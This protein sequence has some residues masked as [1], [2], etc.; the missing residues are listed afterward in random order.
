MEEFDGF[1][2]ASGGREDGAIVG[3]H[4][5]E[6]VL[7]VLG[8]IDAWLGRD[9]KFGTEEGTAGAVSPER[10]EQQTFA[11]EESSRNKRFLICEL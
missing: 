9:A 2:G 8:V 4:D 3:L 5:F 7:E 6:P 1:L 10:K 11:V